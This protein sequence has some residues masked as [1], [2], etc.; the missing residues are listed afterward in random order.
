MGLIAARPRARLSWRMPLR[1]GLLWLLAALGAS[2]LLS[3]LDLAGVESALLGAGAEVPAVAVLLLLV[4]AP[5]APLFLGTRALLRAIHERAHGRGA[6]R[7]AAR[8]RR[9]LPPEHT[10]I[11]HYLP[12]D[13]GDGEVDVVVVGPTGVFALEVQEVGGA[14]ACYQDVWYRAGRG[15]LTP[16]ADSPS[17]TAA[18][19]ARRVA[20]DVATAGF[21]RTPVQPLVVFT[22]ARAVDVA[23]SSV[24]ALSGVDEVV[25]HITRPGFASPQR[26]QAIARALAGAGRQAAG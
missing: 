11:T 12:R 15:R 13:H 20:A 1:D 5:L 8:L 21:T 22:R 24:P 6:G 23:T 26:T 25:A 10:V 4:L 17:R 9:S 16:L 3:H 7:L 2:L 14:V 18:W 19:H